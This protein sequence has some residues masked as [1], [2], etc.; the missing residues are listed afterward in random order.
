METVSKWQPVS[1]ILV[2]DDEPSIV[3]LL[4]EVVEAEGHRVDTAFNGA[5][6]RAKLSQRPYDLIICDIIMPQLGGIGLYTELRQCNEPLARKMVFITGD[7]SEETR[8]FLR[9][10]GSRFLEKP[11]AVQ[12]LVDVMRTLLTG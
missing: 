6:A 10:T 7:L 5:E 4:Q 9:Q 11:F 2:V 3:R 1:N 8:G 12:D